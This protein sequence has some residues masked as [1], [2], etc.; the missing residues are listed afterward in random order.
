L[1]RDNRS[2]Q[3]R[4]FGALEKHLS[5]YFQTA[6]RTRTDQKCS[7]SLPL[8]AEQFLGAAA[9]L[10]WHGKWITGKPASALHN[11]I[12]ARHGGELFLAT[13]ACRGGRDERW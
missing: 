4:R 12:S 13:R 6:A 5:K 11:V 9:I 8:H 3:L 2:T 1:G 10:E 7:S